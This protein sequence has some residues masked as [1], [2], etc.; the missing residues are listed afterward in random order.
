MKKSGITLNNLT[1]K[2]DKNIELDEAPW[3]LK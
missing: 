2:G 3:H 1:Y